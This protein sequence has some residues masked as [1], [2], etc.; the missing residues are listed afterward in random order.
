MDRMQFIGQTYQGFTSSVDDIVNFFD[1]TM[2]AYE[3][4]GSTAANV[5]GV[6]DIINKTLKIQA[7]LRD[8]NELQEVVDIINN[9]LHNRKEVYGRRFH[10]DAHAEGP[11]IE[12]SVHEDY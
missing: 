5:H 11:Y 7:T 1:H 3:I 9:T 4:V 2:A 8:D 12:M 6:T 10:V